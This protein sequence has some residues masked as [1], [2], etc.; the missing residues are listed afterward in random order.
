MCVRGIISVFILFAGFPGFAQLNLVS[1][2][3]TKVF[4]GVVR[5]KKDDRPLQFSTVTVLS[6]QRNYLSDSS[7]KFVIHNLPEGR[8]SIR[9]NNTG[10]ASLTKEITI[11]GTGI[12][13]VAASESQLEQVVVTAVAG[14]T[15]IKRT[16]VSVAIISQKEMNRSTSTNV[17]DALLKSVPG[18]SAITTGPNISKPFI[19]GLGYNRVLTLYDGIR[20]EGQQW[21]DE[22]GIEIDPYGIG[23]AEIVKG[24]ASLMYGS[25]AIA[26]VV[27]LIPGAPAETDGRIKGDAVTEYHSNNN[28]LGATLGLDYKKNGFLWSTR[29]STKSA[30]NYRNNVDGRVYNTGFK[31]KNLSAMVGWEKANSK[32]YIQLNVYDNLQEIPDGSRDSLSRAFTYQTKEA[33]KDDVRNRLLVPGE[34]LATYTISPLHQHIQHYRLYHKGMYLLGTGELFTLVGFQQNIRREYNHPT[35]PVQA[36]LYVSLNTINYEA[37][38]SFPEW[39]GIRFTY[40]VNGMYQENKNKNATDFPIPDYKLF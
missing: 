11:P 20:Q 37:K 1:P 7:G 26:G 15:K 9:I 6:L 35:V 2:V 14:A 32:N 34:R 22:H 23:R 8:Y 4:E 21:G 28:M 13:H 40:G 38:Y 12:F 24:P 29:G 16:P 33:D 18:I 36:G 31:E 17:I 5:D 3:N 19:R 10:Y 30:M 27:N 25:D 39:A